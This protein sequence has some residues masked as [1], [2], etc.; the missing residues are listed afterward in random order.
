MDL[1]LNNKQWLIF[2]K[3][4]QTNNIFKFMG[5]LMPNPAL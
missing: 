2:N 3:T 1:A 4:K 5:Y